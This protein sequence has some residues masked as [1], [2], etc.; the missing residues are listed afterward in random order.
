M[1]GYIYGIFHNERCIYVGSTKDFTTRRCNHVCDSNLYDRPV[2]NYI[3]SLQNKWCEIKFKIFE[4]D[5]YP[6]KEDRFKKEREYYD[7]YKDQVLNNNL[8]WK[9]VEDIINK[10]R[11]LYQEN[12]EYYKQRAKQYYEKNKE[13]IKRINL[14]R[15]YD[16]KDEQLEKMIEYKAKN[17]KKI[18]EY[19]KN[20]RENNKEYFKAYQKNYR[21]KKKSEQTK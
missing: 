9:S 13:F 1:K 4:E 5:E 12:K 17:L 19:Q 6:T 15:Y 16:N 8:P 20:Y 14:E 21:E 10:R 11:K 2:Y 18:K 7:Q 3:N